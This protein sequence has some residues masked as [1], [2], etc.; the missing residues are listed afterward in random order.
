[1]T[2]DRRTR[3]I[4]PGA[5]CQRCGDRYRQD[6]PFC[7]GCAGERGVTP[8][9]ALAARLARQA[10]KQAQIDRLKPPA[11][12]ERQARFLKYRGE[13]FEVAWDGTDGSQP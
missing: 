1:M 7:R 12:P 4:P 5:R 11:P 13:W 8:A 9:A 10:E 6:G 2:P 3:P